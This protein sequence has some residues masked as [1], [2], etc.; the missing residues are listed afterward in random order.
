VA[1]STKGKCE[2]GKKIVMRMTDGIV[3]VT[4]RVDPALVKAPARAFRYQRLL[5]ERRCQH[6]R[7]GEGR[8][9]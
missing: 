5:D 3:P 1:L 9:E 2:A 8:R 7:D 4:T 6:R